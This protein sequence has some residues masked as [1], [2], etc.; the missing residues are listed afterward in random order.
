MFINF[1]VCQYI[2]YSIDP[3]TVKWLIYGKFTGK[4]GQQTGKF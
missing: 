3:I 2:F 4:N 1:L